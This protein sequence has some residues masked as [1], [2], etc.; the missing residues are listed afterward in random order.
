MN[1]FNGKYSVGHFVKVFVFKKSCSDHTFPHQSLFRTSTTLSFRDF[2]MPQSGVTPAERTKPCVPVT[3]HP[4]HVTESGKSTMRLLAVCF[5]AYLWS[6]LHPGAR[7][8]LSVLSLQSFLGSNFSHRRHL[9]RFYIIHLSVCEPIL[10]KTIY[11]YGISWRLMT[12]LGRPL[13]GKFSCKT[14]SISRLW[15][16]FELFW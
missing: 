2:P 3:S 1:V 4:G 11:Y 7:V 15:N 14:V 5:N 12:A 13:D 8:D 9:A 16:F 10:E 6:N